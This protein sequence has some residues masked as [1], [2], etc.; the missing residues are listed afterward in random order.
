MKT[1][2]TNPEHDLALVQNTGAWEEP[3]NNTRYIPL[4]DAPLLG[5]ERVLPT[6][7][8]QL[9]YIASHVS[10]GL[11]VH[12]RLNEKGEKFPTTGW[13]RWKNL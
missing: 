3:Y 10:V 13:T 1:L 7:L 11:E 5:S 8:R 4:E 2:D 6:Y 9:H 12:D